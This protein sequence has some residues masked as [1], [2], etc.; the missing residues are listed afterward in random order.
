MF[1]SH[2]HLVN[3]NGSFIHT[4]AYHYKY[5]PYTILQQNTKLNQVTQIFIS[6]HPDLTWWLQEEILA[7]NTCYISFCKFSPNPFGPVGIYKEYSLHCHVIYNFQISVLTKQWPLVHFI[8][9]SLIVQTKASF[10]LFHGQL[11]LR[12]GYQF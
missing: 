4:I 2:L 1:T 8:T 11:N 5:I 9:H 7:Y 12:T 3:V 10:A 6:S